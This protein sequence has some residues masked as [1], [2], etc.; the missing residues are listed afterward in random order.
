MK[1]RLLIAAM[2]TLAS[3][4]LAGCATPLEPPT[5]LTDAE[6]TEFR[7][8]QLER[9][10]NET[11]LTAYGVDRLEIPVERYI[12]TDEY[13]RVMDECVG[14]QN[15]D[16][17]DAGEMSVPLAMNLAWYTCT[18]L[19]PLEP[20][21]IGVIGAS[22]REYIYDY[23]VRWLVPCLES[24]GYP[25][26]DAPAREVFVASGPSVNAWTPWGAIDLPVRDADQIALGDRCGYAPAGLYESD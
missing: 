22:Q 8:V 4:S 10:W 13:N 11:G 17:I 23:Y 24:A 1:S 5:G 20:S 15:V 6:K 19:Y 25:V 16:P 3:A 2:I 18:A 7:D 9:A 21:K 14:G 26:S 12:G